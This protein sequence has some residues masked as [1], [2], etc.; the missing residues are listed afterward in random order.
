M[1][2]IIL[3]FRSEI[4]DHRSGGLPFLSV[5]IFVSELRIAV[6]N[7]QDESR[8]QIQAVLN[9]APVFIVKLVPFVKQ[10]LHCRR[11]S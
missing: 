1:H 11:S 3:G 7:D 5:S 2:K 8:I 10:E 4:T 6:S 9:E